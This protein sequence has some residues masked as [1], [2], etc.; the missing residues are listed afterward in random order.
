MGIRTDRITSVHPSEDPLLRLGATQLRG[1]QS[2]FKEDT[3]SVSIFDESRSQSPLPQESPAERS[4]HHYTATG[5][6]IPGK[7]GWYVDTESGV[8]HYIECFD[9]E[10]A[11][12]RAWVIRQI[13]HRSKLHPSDVHLVRV[14]DKLGIATEK[15]PFRSQVDKDPAKTVGINAKDYLADYDTPPQIITREESSINTRYT[16][17]QRTAGTAHRLCL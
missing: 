9:D 1:K 11:A 16:D 15:K 13:Y 6:T 10:S 3:S 5:E 7:S 2:D 17:S 14:N 4:D 12:R 8:R